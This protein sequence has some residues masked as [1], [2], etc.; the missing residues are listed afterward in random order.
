MKQQQQQ[1]QNKTR[2][3]PPALKLGEGVMK[4]GRQ[5]PIEEA[6]ELVGVSRLA[7]QRQHQALDV[8]EELRRENVVDVLLDDRDHLPH[9]TLDLLVQLLGVDAWVLQ[10]H[11]QTHVRGEVKG[12]G[13]G[14]MVVRKPR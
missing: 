10:G 14:G 12:H 5:L 4:N 3:P 11:S 9:H 13:E 8:G 2:P 1:Q 6:G 7:H